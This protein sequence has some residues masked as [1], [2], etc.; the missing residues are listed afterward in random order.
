[1][2]VNTS[3]AAPTPAPLPGGMMHGTVEEIS[4]PHVST[5]FTPT[6]PGHDW[7]SG[8]AATSAGVG[9]GITVLMANLPVIG[10][11]LDSV[12]T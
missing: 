5:A 4:G 1:M 10:A 12:G 3:T 9:I 6:V 7:T 11:V 8:V 2:W